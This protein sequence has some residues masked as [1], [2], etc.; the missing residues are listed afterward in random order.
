MSVLC[1][2]SAFSASRM[3]VG[4]TTAWVLVSPMQ[5]K[6][7]SPILCC[8]PE[9]PQYHREISFLSPPSINPSSSKDSPS[10]WRAPTSRATSMLRTAEPRGWWKGQGWVSHTWWSH[11]PALHPEQHFILSRWKL[12]LLPNVGKA[13]LLKPGQVQ[14]CCSLYK[15]CRKLSNSTLQHLHV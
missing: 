8:F 12:T 14:F 3:T 6:I 7:I 11:C 10:D 9:M 4:T 1:N 13:S 15:S 2:L 5:C